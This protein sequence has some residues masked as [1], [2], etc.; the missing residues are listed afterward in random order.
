MPPEYQDALY[1][2]TAM[3]ISSS[4]GIPVPPDVYRHAMSSLQT[5]RKNNTAIPKLQMPG[6]YASGID[7]SNTIF[8]TTEGGIVIPG[9]ANQTTWS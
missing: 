5:I 1:W 2:N 8:G 4:Y 6:E 9:V 7:V 3:R